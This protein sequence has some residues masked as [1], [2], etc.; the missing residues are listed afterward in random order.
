MLAET[1]RRFPHVCFSP[2]I[3]VSLNAS[4]RSEVVF[5]RTRTFDFD[6]GPNLKIECRHNFLKKVRTRVD[7]I[8]FNSV[9]L[10][11][12]TRAK[13]DTSASAIAVFVL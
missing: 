8:R 3:V 6:F 4:A 11:T 13:N 5:P 12:Y 10:K 9:M 1:W 7:I 2:D